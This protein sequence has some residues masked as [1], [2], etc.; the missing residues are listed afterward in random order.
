MTIEILYGEVCNLFGDSGN[1]SYLKASIPEA[2][3]INTELNDTPY[4]VQ[5]DVDMIYLGSGT[6]S[7]QKRVI[8]KLMPFKER[9]KELID[10]GKVILVTGNMTDILCRTIDYGDGDKID[11]IGLVPLDVKV[12]FNNRHNSLFLGKFQDM[13]VVGF[14][15]RFS[16]AYGDIAG[17]EFMQVERGIGINREKM[18]D[19]IR[20][21]NLYATQTIGPLLPLNPPFTKYIMGILKAEHTEPAFWDVSMEAYNQRLRE[22][23]NP[24]TKLN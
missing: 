14:N 23:K 8:E 2:T 11:A 20:I 16:H 24:E 9:I 19:G 17:R 6:E 15:S 7:I 13:D 4:F 18:T 21:N 3:W 12:E 10:A 1:I 22:Y 5:H